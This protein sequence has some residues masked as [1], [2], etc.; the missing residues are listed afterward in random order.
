MTEEKRRPDTEELEFPFHEYLLEDESPR[1]LWDHP[2]QDLDLS[3]SL[4]GTFEDRLRIL[5]QAID[6]ID[7][8][9]LLRKELNETFG[10]LLKDSRDWVSGKLNRFDNWQFGYKPSVDFRR[11]S[12]ERE[13]LGIYRDVRAEQQRAFTDIASLRRERRKLVIEYES[14]KVTEKALAR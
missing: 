14:L 10:N 7:T 12:L 1:D 4:S 13:L 8:E 3:E 5:R 9:I 2:I 11:T 6:E